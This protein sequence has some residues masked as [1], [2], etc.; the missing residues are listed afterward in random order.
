M[1]ISRRNVLKFIA[2]GGSLSVFGIGYSGVAKKMTDTWRDNN[3]RVTRALTGNAPLPEYTIDPA[4]GRVTPNP[5]QYIANTVCVGCTSLCGVRVRVDRE[6]EQ[7]IRVTGNP[8][9]VLSADPFL[10]YDTPIVDS[11]RALSAYEEAGLTGRATACGRGNAVLDKLYD[12]YRVLTPLKRV[13]R[14]GEGRWEPITFEQLLEEIVEGGDLF[15]EGHVD[16]LRAI[17]DNETLIDPDQPELGTLANQLVFIGG[18]KEGR[19]DL[20]QRFVMFAFGSINFSGH[21]GNCGLTMRSAYASLL[22]DWKGQPHLKPD[23]RNAKF[24]LNVG[25]APANAGNPFKRQGKLIAEGRSDGNLTYVVVDPV[26]TNSDSIAAGERSRWIPITPGT[27]G[28]LAMG[29]IRWIIENERYAESFLRQPNPTAAENA[30]EPSWSNATHLV[31]TE[32]EHP[33]N[34]KLLRGSQ[35]GLIELNEDASNETF[36]V[37]VDG[38]P[39]AHNVPTGPADLFFSGTVEIEGAPVAVATAMSLLKDAAFEHTLAEYSEITGI[40]ASQIEGLAEE[41]TSHGRQAAAD[42]HGGTMHSNGFYSAWAVVMLNAMVGNLNWKG[43]TSAGGGAWKDFA[44]GP[45]YNMK[46]FSGQVAFGGARVSR[47]GMPYEKTTEFKRRKDAGDNPYPARHPWYPLGVALQSEYFPG[48]LN[49]YPYP[50]KALILWN[51]NPLYGQSGLQ[52]Q[53]CD[54]LAD[55]GH[56]PLIISI[57]P[58]INETSAYADYIVPDTVLYETWGAAK[59]WGA[60]LTKVN[61][62]RWPVV[63]PP[64]ARTPA[65]D[66]ISMESFFIELAKALNLPG[67]GDNAIADADGNLHGLHHPEDYFLRAYANIAFDGEPVPEANEDD[68][69]FTNVERLT[70]MLQA[71]LKPDEWRRVAYVLARGGRFEPGSGAYNGDF[72]AHRYS[73]AMQIYDEKPATT[74]NSM[75]GKRFSGVPRWIPPQFADGTPLH[76][77]YPTTEFPFTAVSTKSQLQSPHSIGSSKL[78][79]IQPANTIN[80]NFEDGAALGIATGDRIRV[81]SP[82]GV[83]EG[84]AM[85]LRGLMRGVIGIEHGFGHW[86]LGAQPVIVNNEKWHASD[87]RGAGVAINLLG[88]RDIARDGVSTLADVACGANAR[89]GIPVKVERLGGG[90]A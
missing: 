32:P 74:K 51:T 57:D 4:T 56:I 90:H 46:A 88:L 19:I 6:S 61:S 44:P 34:G 70:D 80:L 77:V 48:M 38:V 75:N 68:M 41:F 55:P 81:T 59:P 73:G 62:V 69:R 40:P 28:A 33:N 7:V 37:M 15:G 18:F 86:A 5:A 22:G 76:E 66:P 43:G 3:P 2:A 67:F 9:H 24:I 25:T 14:R 53:A 23:F 78:D 39:T 58:F 45:R 8:Y 17:Q 36:V 29:M 26:L 84:V 65:G 31:I 54:M 50:T 83:I 72:V 27:D 52:E 1:T 35:L 49:G 60:W 47:R 82:N 11:F 79:A 10:E 30:G 89:Q 71:T 21:R 20:A 63:E 16:G 13:G 87:I 85:L 64:Q 12:P 42:C